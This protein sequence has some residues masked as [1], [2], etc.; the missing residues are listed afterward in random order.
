MLVYG[1]DGH[2]LLGGSDI[3]DMLIRKL[4]YD[5]QIDLLRR[6]KER[7]TP[8]SPPDT[9]N[10]GTV[11]T[12][13]D[14]EATLREGGFIKKSLSSMRDAYVGAKV[15]WKRG[16]GEDDPPVGE[17]LTRNSATGAVRFI[18][19]LMWEDMAGDVD[20]ILLFGGPTESPYFHQHLAERFGAEKI[21]T[22]AELLPALTGTPDLELVGISIGACYSYEGSYSPLYLNRIPA[23]ITLENLQTGDKVEYEPFQNFTQTF[24][25]FQPFVSEPL[26]QQKSAPHKYELTVTYPNGVVI[27]QH[28]IDGYVKPNQEE[29]EQQPDSLPR[30]PA[31]SLR[32]VIDRFGRVGV[33]KHSSGPGLPWTEMFVIVRTPPWQTHLQHAALETESRRVI[34]NITKADFGTPWTIWPERGDLTHSTGYAR[35]RRA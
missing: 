31:T 30:L 13:A 19:Q 15:L 9:L 14:V 27:E 21:I 17:I 10:D 29:R 12:W 16:E 24:K 28:S 35:G 4:D 1:A 22:A 20:G 7:L 33:E 11:V 34:E 18:W 26:E 2:P 6:A 5:G 23:S 8:S 25:P 32:L 3:D